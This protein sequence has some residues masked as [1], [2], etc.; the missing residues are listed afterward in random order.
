MPP[1]GSG[2]WAYRVPAA[3]RSQSSSNP[4]ERLR[5][6]TSLFPGQSVYT[7]AGPS[8]LCVTS[9]CS[10][11]TPVFYTPTLSSVIR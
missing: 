1:E 6:P 9:S 10:C 7:L 2:T 4:L 5:F 8:L 3:L 11:P